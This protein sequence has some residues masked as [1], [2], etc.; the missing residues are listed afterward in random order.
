M[1]AGYDGTVRIDTSLNTRGFNTGLKTMTNSLGKFAATM[2]V[3]LG[4]G[5]LIA[6]GRTATST[7]AQS[8]AAWM[9]LQSVVEGTGGSF[10]GAKKFLEEYIKDGLVPMTNAV[11]AYKNL[12]ARGYDS[13]QI[14]TTLTALKNASAFGRQASLS[15]GQAVQSATEGLKNENSILVDNSGVTKNVSLMWKDYAASIGTTVGNLTKQ[16]KIQAEVNGILEETRFQMGDATKLSGGYAGRVAALGTSFYNLKV[17]VGS[18]IMPILSVI[19]PYIKAAIDQLVIFFNMVAQIISALFGI[20]LGGATAATQ[21]LAGATEDLAGAQGDLAKNTGKSGKAAKGALAAFDQINVLQKESGEGGG[22]GGGVG[23]ALPLPGTEEANS[24]ID[25][26]SAKVEELKNKLLEFFEPLQAPFDHLVEAATT[27]GGSIWDG[28]TWVWENILEPL[29]IW[30]IQTVA[31]IFIDML[32]NSLD[33][34]TGILEALKPLGIW[35]WENFLQPIA[36]WTGGVIVDILTGINDALKN[37]SDWIRENQKTVE[38]IIIL[39]GSL[40]LAWGLVNLAFTAWNVIA[41]IGTAVTAGF[42][43]VMA[44]LTSP[45]TLVV[46]A[47]AALIAIVVLLI[48]NWD[49]VKA[50]ALEVWEKIKIAWAAAGDWIRLHVTDPIKNAFKTALDWVEKRWDELWT[51]T[52]DAAKIAIN[53]VIGFVNGMINAIV[54]GINA[55]I[56]A[57]N[58]IQIKVPSWIPG[59]GGNTWGLKLAEVVAPQIPLLA[60]GA[61]IPPNSSFLAMLGDQRTGTNIE[62]PENLLRQIIQEEV[63]RMQTDVKIEFGGS[64]GAL[65]RELK[66]HIERETVRIGRSMVTGGTA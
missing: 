12:A 4:L 33:I 19:I 36:E 32:A 10:S 55:V 21:E 17:A 53:T 34:I 65:V 39:A 14:E 52:K 11:T 23:T 57:L 37:F 16:Q 6:F 62:T 28:L 64:L 44:I 2:G 18:A 61:V 30:L 27:L 51:G 7:A 54:V 46:L 29:G 20:Q 50:K 26:V 49:D 41:G 8:Q 35:L 24:A 3:A 9:G 58:S 63:G 25:Q 47:I 31:P 56:R 40:A 38:T 42:G 60:K 1:A 66:P 45:I 22:P 5:A 13:S 43:I 48:R 15:M 59:I